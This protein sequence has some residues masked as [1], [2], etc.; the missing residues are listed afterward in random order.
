MVVTRL[1]V[2]SDYGPQPLQI[3]NMQVSVEAWTVHTAGVRFDRAPWLA[4]AYSPQRQRLYSSTVTLQP[5]DRPL[6]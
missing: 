6:P 4:M 2:M 1:T 3:T 5:P